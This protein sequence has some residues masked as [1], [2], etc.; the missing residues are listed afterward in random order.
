MLTTLRSKSGGIIAKIFIGLLAASFAVWGI[1]DMLRGRVPDKL[2]TVG[3]REIG[4]SEFRDTFNRELRTYSQRLNETITPDRARE[5]GLD[6][7]ILGDLMRDAAL[8]SQAEALG[9]RMPARAVAQ[10]VADTKQF[11]TADGAFNADRFRQ[12]LRSN[13]I[14]EEQFFAIETRNMTRQ[15]ISRPIIAE[16]V[17]PDTLVELI[18][19]HRNEQRDASW[20]EISVPSL[21]KQ[22]SDAD[23]KALY[24]ENPAAFTIPERRTF[25]VVALTPEAIASSIEV[26]EDELKQQYEATKQNYST[27]ETRTVLQIPFPSEAEAQAAAEKIKAGT[28]FEDVAKERGLSEQDMTLGTVK[29]T[30]IPDPAIADA[31]FALADGAVSDVIKGRL[32]TVLLKANV[33]QQGSTKTLEEVRDQVA[34]DVRTRKA[35]DLLLDLHDKFED[36]RAG[37]ATMDEAAKEISVPVTV[38]G[39][40]S[41]D[42]NDTN[43]QTVTVPGHPSVLQTAFET[44]IG[45]EIS[46]LTDGD[47]GFTWVETR[48]IVPSSVPAFN[49]VKDKVAE[50]WKAREAA[51]AT[52][53]KAEELVTKLKGGTPI[54][55]LAA[56]ENAEVKT[57]NG[58]SR[59]AASAEFT[60]SDVAALFSVPA[61]GFTFAMSADGKSARIIASSPVLGQAYDPASTEAD[62]IREVLRTNLANDLYAEYVAALQ[63][64]IG[65]TIDDAAWSRL[66]GG[67]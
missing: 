45:L 59:T 64:D 2:A 57:R 28:S 67:Q 17:V 1:E 3:E 47:N 18:W 7:Q 38:I 34:A 50:A 31:A 19:R 8:D 24:D 49:D 54:A 6:R 20:F 62:A 21:D 25:A 22:P 5:L 27:P 66:R 12:I 32:S 4:I 11:Q 16:P 52:R 14:S 44:E 29:K 42:G 53:A 13:G 39:P 41:R 65:V 58:V 15:V 48:D 9:I 40:V 23:L 51:K 10:S 43:G 30:D 36:A 37:G 33:V 63:E 35:R 60:P 26:S 55:D 56:A 61:D 46:P